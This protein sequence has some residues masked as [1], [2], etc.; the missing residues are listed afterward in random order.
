[1]SGFARGPLRRY[2]VTWNSGHVETIEAH[3]VSWPNAFSITP[4]ESREPWIR[5]MGE[6]A[7]QWTLVLQARE[8]DLRSVR[9]VTN[10]ENLG[11]VS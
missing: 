9:D 11:G 7:G 5:F 4:D 6:V 10:A 3:Q 2:E 1:M 8:P